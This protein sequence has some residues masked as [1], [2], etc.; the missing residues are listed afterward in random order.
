VIGELPGHKKFQ[1]RGKMFFPLLIAILWS[2]FEL[3]NSYYGMGMR[4]TPY[5]IGE[6]VYSF[7]FIYILGSTFFRSVF[8]PFILIAIQIGYTSESRIGLWNHE[9][10]PLSELQRISMH[11]AIWCAFICL[12]FIINNILF[13]EY[14]GVTNAVYAIQGTLFIC[15]NLSIIFLPIIPVI[16]V[17]RNKKERLM[18]SVGTMLQVANEKYLT[19]Q[20][21]GSEDVDRTKDSLDKLVAYSLYVA[22]IRTVPS[23]V[24]VFNTSLFS[25]MMTVLPVIIV[26]IIS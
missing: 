13:E 3:Q 26:V 6:V 8:F 7:A 19:A 5:L 24:E 15:L 12:W 4:Y 23:S 9:D 2:L 11:G 18:T 1:L 20:F 10:L 25:I 22:S 14:F 16:L 21:N 17:L